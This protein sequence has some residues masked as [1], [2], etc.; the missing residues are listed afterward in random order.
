M[1]RGCTDIWDHAPERLIAESLG[2]TRIRRRRRRRR[3]RRMGRR[4][5]RRG[6]PVP[7]FLSFPLL[8]SF[9]RKRESKLG[10]HA[11]GLSLNHPGQIKEENGKF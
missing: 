7:L 4:R 6:N 2:K 9:P 8:P 5:R 11:H 3:R 1:L 10:P